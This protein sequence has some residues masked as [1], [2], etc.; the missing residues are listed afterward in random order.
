MSEDQINNIIDQ[1]NKPAVL[2]Y[3]QPAAFHHY[4]V[5]HGFIRCSN[6]CHKNADFYLVNLTKKL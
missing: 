3:Y 2:Y 5:R 6:I 4:I 1:T